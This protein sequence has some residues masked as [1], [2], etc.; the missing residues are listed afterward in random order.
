[1]NPTIMHRIAASLVIVGIVAGS[2]QASTECAG[3][4]GVHKAALIELYTSEGCS[5]CPP[6]DRWL[7]TLVPGKFT[8]AQVV[9]LALHVDYWNYLGWSDPFSDPRFSARQRNLA[10]INASRAVYTPGVVVNGA[11]YRQWFSEARFVRDIAAINQTVPGADIDAAFG[12]GQ[13]REIRI[14]VKAALRD[15]SGAGDADVYFA[16]YE[17]ALEN[18]VTAG[19][20]GGALLRHDHVARAWFGPFPIGPD[21]RASVERNVR[22]PPAWKL[23]DT[24]VVAFVQKRGT[25]EVLQAL[26]V[27][28]CI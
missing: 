14:S 18:R 27:P 17:N 7:G 19:E 24:G 21:G 12:V 23:P 4:S 1:M 13:D 22:I 5:S 6:A 2:A 3:K 28:S 11:E 9:P 26:A 25:A 8:F 10:R 15:P 20:N 16:V